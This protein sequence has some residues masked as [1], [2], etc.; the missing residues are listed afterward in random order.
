MD[1]GIKGRKA[2]VCASSRG[3]GKGCAMA[4]AN[5]GVSL[6]GVTLGTLAQPVPL[7]IA[8]GLLLGKT[9]G[10]FGAVALTVKLGLA[11]LPEGAG[12]MAMLGTAVLCGVGFTMS[13]FIASLAFEDAP[14]A[15][16]AQTRLGILCGSL[17][18]GAIGYAILHAALKPR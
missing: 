14:A 4:L 11:R 7:G 10:V 5:A 6:E 9:T 3:L 18:A 12:W 16:A 17:F 8:L 2:I 1:L 15:F 13:L